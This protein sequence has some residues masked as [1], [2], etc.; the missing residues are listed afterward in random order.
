MCP[1][2]VNYSL[3]YIWCILLEDSLKDLS[4]VWE[5]DACGGSG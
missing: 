3:G 2:V 4:D 1:V 5:R